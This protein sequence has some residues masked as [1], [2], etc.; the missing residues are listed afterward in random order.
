MS[1]CGRS[2]TFESEREWFDH[3]WSQFDPKLPVAVWN[4]GL[5][6]PLYEANPNDMRQML[7][8][9]RSLNHLVGTQQQRLRDG[10]SN[11][12][13]SFQ[14]DYQLEFLRLLNREVSGFRAL[15][16]FIHEGCGT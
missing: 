11:R 14:V 1:P 12:L 5:P 15:Q 16:D 13:R 2:A 4:S 3:Q 8:A 6:R 9:A 7:T 10:D